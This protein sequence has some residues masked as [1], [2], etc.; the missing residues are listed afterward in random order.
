MALTDFALFKARR[1]Y[2]SAGKRSRQKG[3]RK[4]IFVTLDPML[5]HCLSLLIFCQLIGYTPKQY[6]PSCIISLIILYRRTI[7]T[8]SIAYLALINMILEIQLWVTIMLQN[9][10]IA[11]NWSLLPTLERDNGTLFI[12]PGTHLQK[13]HSKNELE[14]FCLQYSELRMLMLTSTHW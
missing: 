11:Y 2:S 5:S 14:N 4:I 10:N 8:F 7:R 12:P 3:L 13:G 9:L 6:L 1:F